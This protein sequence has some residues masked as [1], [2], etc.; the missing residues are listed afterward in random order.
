MAKSNNIHSLSLI[1]TVMA[2]ISLSGCSNQNYSEE[3]RGFFSEKQVTRWEHGMVSGNGVTGAL[4]YGLPLAD[5]IIMSSWDLYMPLNEPLPPVDMGAHLD[6]IR[7]MMFGGLYGEASE[8]VVQ[9]SREEGYGNKR[10]TDPFVPGFDLIID[11]P[12]NGSPEKYERSVNFMTGEISTSWDDEGGSWLRK[13][14]VSRAD[15]VIV[16]SITNLSGE[17]VNCSV[18]LDRRPLVFKGYFDRGFAAGDYT[19]TTGEATIA[20][21]GTFN[22]KWEGSLRGCEGVALIKSPGGVMESSGEAIKIEGAREVQIL[23]DLK[24]TFG[25]PGT[26]IEALTRKLEAINGNYDRLLSRHVKVHGEIFARMKLNLDDSETGTGQPVEEMLSLNKKEPVFELIEKQFDAGRYN[27]LSSTGVN[28]PNLQGMWAGSWA[29]DWSGDYTQNGNLPVAMASMMSGNMPELMQAY[30]SYQSRMM[31]HSRIN[32]RN[33]YGARGIHIASRT[34][35]HGLNNHFDRTWPMTFWT[36]GA[37]WA[38][39]FYYDYWLYTGDEKFLRESAFPFMKESVLFYEDFLITGDNGKYIFIPSYSPENN[40]ANI[41]WQACINAT[42]DVM[43][44]KQLL[45]NCIAAARVVGDTS[46][47]SKWN[48][49]LLKMP[50]YEVNS[51]GALRE[52]MWPGAE[53]NYA[54][55]HASHLYGLFDIADPEISGS[56]I[57]T[58]AARVAVQKRMEVRRQENGGIMAFGMVQLAMSA[59]ALGEG[60]MA[61]EA[62]RWLSRNYWSPSLVTT[63]DPGY[64]FNL[65]LSGGFPALIIRMLAYSEPGM[66]SLLPALPSVWEK[67]SIE[68]LLLRGGIT[69]NSLKWNGDTIKAEMISATDQEVILELPGKVKPI[70]ESG[71]ITPHPSGED[72]KLM[73]KLHSNK[74]VVLEFVRD[75][76][77]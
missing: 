23:V 9:L 56:T 3:D 45:R 44:A 58:E 69:V 41:E 49:M 51:E 38:S 26:G 75:R 43:V 25:E 16:V 52:W 46:E 53:E 67:G 33:L 12:A 39:N 47:V 10:W 60:E 24:G 20:Y 28:P 27:I 31:E 73:L 4:V 15:S 8:Y 55:R 17:E 66:I 68:G 34:S 22:N 50:D 36:A 30:F 74:K 1:V 63:H 61:W 21:V 29:A 54:H 48:Q 40:P 65:D 57:L 62:V 14:F 71:D 7:E 70:N 72:G 59:A 11:H 37:G 2:G 42:M 19:V 32:A 6:T 13:V 64:I 35:S 18:S 76:A 77:E 5:T